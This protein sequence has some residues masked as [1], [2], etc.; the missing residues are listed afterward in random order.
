MYTFVPWQTVVTAYLEKIRRLSAYIA[1]FGSIASYSS[2]G[3]NT[4]FWLYI[5]PDVSPITRI[6][7]H[8]QPDFTWRLQTHFFYSVLTCLQVNKDCLFRPGLY[9]DE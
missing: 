1:L 8:H 3:R 7:Y 6:R 4:I 9:K 5:L 2:I